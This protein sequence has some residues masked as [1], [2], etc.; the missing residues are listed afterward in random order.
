MR[1]T[2][3]AI[4][5]TNPCKEQFRLFCD[6][7]G[8]R[9]YVLVTARNLAL[10]SSFG[11]YVPWLLHEFP[12]QMR[13]YRSLFL[14]CPKWAYY[15]ALEL[16]L[17]GRDDTRKLASK[18]SEYALIYAMYVD[19]A[20]H[21]D[22]RTGACAPDRHYGWR[23][24]EY[25]FSVDQCPR[26]DT[27]AAACRGADAAYRYA[28]NIDR[29]PRDDTRTAAC[30]ESRFALQYS[31]FVDKCPHEETIAAVKGTDWVDY[32]IRWRL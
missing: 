4:K 23:A 5:D 28:R 9:E 16:D 1:I 13:K 2:K 27:R 6:F 12:E 11:I 25:A 26:D 18:D 30:R 17:E 8:D 22:T 3:Q 32:N 21:D 31:L 29:L 14:V 7:L 19:H 15:V 20:A 24:Y 10:A